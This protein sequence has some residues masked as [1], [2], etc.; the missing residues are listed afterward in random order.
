MGL[1]T[2]LTGAGVNCTAAQVLARHLD[3]EAE[4]STIIREIK[5]ETAR[6]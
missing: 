4:I 6:Q 3:S 5:A 1:L 2:F